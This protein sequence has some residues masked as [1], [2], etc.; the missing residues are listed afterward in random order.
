MLKVTKIRDYIYKTILPVLV[1]LFC[2]LPSNIYSNSLLEIK[3]DE[4]ILGEKNAPITIIE[5]ASLSCSH[6]ANFHKKTLPKLIDEYVN[7]GKVR[8]IFRYFPFN[9][10]A[11]IGSMA[12]QCI[13]KD[14]RYDYSSAL[15]EL[16]SDWVKQDTEETK[17]E[18]YKIMQ[19]G[20]MSNDQGNQL[21]MGSIE[22]VR[23][24]HSDR[25]RSDK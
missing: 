17:K 11:L 19:V 2:C 1:I 3:E 21:L 22:R 13:D 15:F 4:Y 23:P 12:L 10:P 14:L 6:C 16:Q 5:Y 7:K 8:I 18:L 9:Y 20:G 25:L 24:D